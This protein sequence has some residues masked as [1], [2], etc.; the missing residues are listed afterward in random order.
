MSMNQETNYE[1]VMRC[2]TICDIW[3]LWEMWDVNEPWRHANLAR[4]ILQMDI[5]FSKFSGFAPPDSPV[6][7]AEILKVSKILTPPR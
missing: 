7:I 4:K 3:E 6:D 5:E 1:N 2:G